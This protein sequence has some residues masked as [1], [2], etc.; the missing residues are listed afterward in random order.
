MHMIRS[1]LHRGIY[2]I[3][4]TIGFW[5]SCSKSNQSIDQPENT[6]SIQAS[7]SSGSSCCRNLTALEAFDLPAGCEVPFFILFATNLEDFAD[8]NLLDGDL[9]SVEFIFLTDCETSTSDYC[10]NV[11]LSLIHI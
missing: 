11:C 3:I 10:H 1:I 9:V 7:Y 5:V 2:L 6:V 8:P 4:L